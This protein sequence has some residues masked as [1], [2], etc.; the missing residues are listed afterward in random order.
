MAFS[1]RE[2][3]LISE[4]DEVQIETRA[5]GR[6]YRTIIWIVVDESELFVRSVRG[7]NGKW[8]QR[9]LANPEVILHAAGTE[10]PARAESATD[11]ISVERTSAALRRK[12]RKGPSLDSMLKTEIFGTTMRL[13]PA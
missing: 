8:Y 6:S 12:Y 2:L 4:S 9:A 11:P 13:D 10:I 5:G 1:D 7:E 3:Q